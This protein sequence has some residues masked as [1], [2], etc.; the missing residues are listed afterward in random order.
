MLLRSQKKLGKKPV[1]K[2]SQFFQH[3]VKHQLQMAVRFGRSK[4]KLG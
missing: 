3:S 4:P 2:S 1:Q